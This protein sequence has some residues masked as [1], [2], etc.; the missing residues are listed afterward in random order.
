LE[1]AGM[2]S[3]LGAKECDRMLPVFPMESS[4]KN[5]GFHGSGNIGSSWLQGADQNS[6]KFLDS[7]GTMSLGIKIVRAT[8]RHGF[9]LD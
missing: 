8:L 3:L 9:G 2:E 5:Q 7:N 4:P 6:V 1:E